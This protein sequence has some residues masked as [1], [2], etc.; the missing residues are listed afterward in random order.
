[1]KLGINLYSLHGMIDTDD[2]LFKA[3]SKLKEIGYDYLQY[4]GAPFEAEKVKKLIDNTAMPVLL[5]HVPMDRI[6][7]QTDKLIEEHIYIGCRNIGLG[8]I[9][10]DITNEEEIKAN[11]A[12]LELAAEKIEAKGCRFFYHHHHYEF[13]KLSDGKTL[14]EYMIENAPHINFTIDT[15]W[16]QYGGADIYDY[17]QKLEGRM[18]CVHLKDYK[19]FSRECKLSPGF[20]PV[21]DG[22]MNFVKLM[23]EMK[24]RGARL[25]IVEQDD[26]SSYE[27]PF[28]QLKRSY[29]YIKK[30]IG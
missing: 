28:Q 17:L 6:I 7:D 18:G 9:S 15:Y 10:G 4:S 5:T 29:D 23:P 24:K 30:V 26:A 21:G 13:Y 25:F 1:M 2:K 20:A 27:D 8:K 12:K 3:V 19:I 16:L 22:T 14:F 11:V